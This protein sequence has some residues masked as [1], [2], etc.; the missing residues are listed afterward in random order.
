MLKKCVNCNKIYTTKSNLNRHVKRC[1]N[2]IQK[3]VL[4]NKK[5]VDLKQSVQVNKI[6]IDFYF[7]PTLDNIEQSRIRYIIHHDRY[8]ERLVEH[9]YINNPMYHNIYIS[10]IM[11]K[12]AYIYTNN[13][14]IKT[15]KDDIIKLLNMMAKIM[16]KIL[17]D[18]ISDNNKDI[19]SKCVQ[20]VLRYVYFYDIDNDKLINNLKLVLINGHHQITNP[21]I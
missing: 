11:I 17:L 8:I 15:D 14:W 13:K 19:N 16:M 5:V 1:N 2:L 18:Y 6:P 4:N 12:N 10:N 7:F 9:I 3:K 20:Q 21:P